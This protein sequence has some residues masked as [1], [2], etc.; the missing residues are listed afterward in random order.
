MPA[1][2]GAGSALPPMACIAAHDTQIKQN[3]AYRR[4]RTRATTLWT[5]NDP[6][7]AGDEDYVRV[8]YVRRGQRRLAIR[9]LSAEHPTVAR[10]LAAAAA[11]WSCL[12][13]S[14]F[15]ALFLISEKPL[16]EVV[17]AGWLIAVVATRRP[18]A[19]R[20]PG[21]APT[22]RAVPPA[23]V[24]GWRRLYRRA[25]PSQPS[26]V[27]PTARWRSRAGPPWRG[28]PGWN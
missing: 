27:R 10:V 12:S 7:P 18:G 3:P 5:P 16:V 8:L 23:A 4:R 17:N 13:Y 26:P 6:G 2:R 14:T 22:R 24:R 20:V 15:G 19:G 28:R 1:V 21:A 11:A 9:L 25:R